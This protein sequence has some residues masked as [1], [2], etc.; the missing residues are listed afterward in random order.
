MFLCCFSLNKIP[1]FLF[2]RLKSEAQLKKHMKNIHSG[3]IFMCE[4]CPKQF[5]TR[6]A[7][8]RH[9]HTH[10][11]EPFPQIVCPECGIMMDNVKYKGHKSLHKRQKERAARPKE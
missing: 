5:K 2:N 11:N 9:K 8:N 4:Q 3:I 1:S 6:E 10:T 7:M